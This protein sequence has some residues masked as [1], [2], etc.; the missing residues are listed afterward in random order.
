MGEFVV[1]MFLVLAVVAVTAVVF[2]GWLVVGVLRVA[3][4]SAA[5]LFGFASPQRDPMLPHICSRPTCRGPNP[6]YARFCRRCGS[7]LD[8]PT[9]QVRRAAAW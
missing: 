1:T 8:S 4:R 2:G 3:W 6:S 7:P 9:R 5:A